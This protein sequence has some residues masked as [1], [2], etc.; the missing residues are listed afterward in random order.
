MHAS[1]TAL[2][3]ASLAFLPLHD[4]APSAAAPSPAAS[5]ARTALGSEAPPSRA[6]SLELCREPRLAG[7]RGSRRAAEWV[8]AELQASGWDV[9]IE[10]RSVLLSLPERTEVSSP[11]LFDRRTRFDPDA[12]PP[13]DLPPF[14]AWAKSGVAE[15][16]VVD[17]GR[18]LRADFERLVAEG[19]AL[20]GTIALASFGGAYR[21]VKVALASEY[22]CAGALLHSPSAEDGAERGETYPR[23]P[24][25]PAH[26]AQRGSILS[27]T[28]APGDP[29]TPGWPSPLLAGPAGDS[30]APNR[31]PLTGPEL[32]ARLPT[33]PALPLGAADAGALLAELAAGNTPTVRIALETRVERRECHN[34]IGSLWPQSGPGGDFVLAGTH[35]DAWVRGAQDSGS[36][37]VALLRAAEHLGA[38]YAD[39]WRPANA[40]RL[41]FWDAEET[42]LV[43]STEWGEAHRGTLEQ[44]LLAYVNGDAC[45]GG[46]NFR[47]S[48]TPGLLGT[49]KSALERVPSAAVADA[50]L[51]EE[52]SADARPRLALPG[53]GSD[54]TVFL[55]HL[56]LPILDLG[57]GGVASG[58]YH[59][60]VDDFALMDRFIDP[61]WV[62]HET[63]GRLFAELLRE[64][65]G[66]GRVSFDA[67]EAATELA[68]AF[69]AHALGGP[70]S[71]ALR[72]VAAPA[73]RVKLTPGAGFYQ[74]LRL[75]GGLPGRPWYTNAL[76]AP[77]R[78]T[79]YAAV[80]LPTVVREVGAEDQAAAAAALGAHILEALGKVANER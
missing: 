48:G 49:L 7:T 38:A 61:T 77:G 26:D 24:W 32:E 3:T 25:K 31:A 37:V 80:L 50:T 22:G 67:S 40:I 39:G 65:S 46:L 27:L 23:G 69:D 56:G 35:R 79:G 16:P 28:E 11:G 45:V 9:D 21:G 30:E 43:G 33:I 70:I 68:L 78:E 1:L 54:Y 17:V 76:W 15:G 59:T 42:G 8:A 41:A 34:V 73:Q 13:G 44:H 19:V 74:R 72:E 66:R 6:L 64:F 55:H 63:A 58:Q 75:P 52:W 60:A 10:T 5:S 12:V 2:I 36:G 47:A 51:W 14:L 62:G 20:E 29:S 18:G 71:D 53:S 4:P 57:F